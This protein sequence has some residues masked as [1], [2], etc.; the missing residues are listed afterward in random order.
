QPDRSGARAVVGRV[1]A[2][3]DADAVA[4]LGERDPTVLVVGGRRPAD[5][6]D[7]LHPMV[8][9]L[10]NAQLPVE[11]TDRVRA[12]GADPRLG[13]PARD[14]DGAGDGARSRTSSL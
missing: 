9:G 2:G 1:V 5:S 12:D 3:P 6:A 10:L 13:R 8:L 7:R 14:D 11:G 4:G